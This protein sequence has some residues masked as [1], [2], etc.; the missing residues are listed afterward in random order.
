MSEGYEVEF[1]PVGNGERSGAAISDRNGT[2]CHYK[3]MIYD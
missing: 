1:L 2:P 3:V